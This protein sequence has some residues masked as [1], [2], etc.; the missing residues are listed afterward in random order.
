MYFSIIVLRQGE[1]LK[2]LK[3]EKIQSVFLKWFRQ[4]QVFSVEIE[5]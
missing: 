3:Y 4:K 2:S 5:W 1:E